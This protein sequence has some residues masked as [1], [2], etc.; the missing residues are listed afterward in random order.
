MK[1]LCMLFMLTGCVSMLIAANTMNV[2]PVSVNAGE[3]FWVEI[4]IDNNDIFAGYQCDIDYPTSFTY[5]NDAVQSERENGH[6]LQKSEVSGADNDDIRLLCFSMPAVAFDGNSGTVVSVKFQASNTPGEYN[7]LLNEDVVISNMTGT[8]I[9]SGYSGGTITVTEVPLPITLASF[10][11]AQTGEGV[12]L[13]WET[14]SETENDH[15]LVY[16]DDKVIA[17]VP[18]AGT[19]SE[20]RSYEYL[21]R[22]AMPGGYTY[23]LADVTLGGTEHVHSERTLHFQVGEDPTVP[24]GIALTSVYPNPFNPS[25]V[26]EY[27]LTFPADIGISIVNTRGETVERLF[28]GPSPAGE[29]SITWHPGDCPGGIYIVRLNAGNIFSTEKVVFLK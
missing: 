28:L 9:I 3:I 11:A 5:L 14:A 2:V 27:A 23:V 29:H 6:T 13:T 4:N 22:T 15:F 19:S 26:I 20:P 16:R 24:S 1:K 25:V 10:T 21:D 18:G 17:T 7:F 8:D 12:R